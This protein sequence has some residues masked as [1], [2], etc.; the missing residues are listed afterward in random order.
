MPIHLKLLAMALFWALT[1]T[2]ARLLA[3]YEAP[4]VMVFGRF[5]IASSAL[6][7]FAYVQRHLTA[8]FDRRHFAGF[9]LLG[10]GTL[11]IA[12]LFLVNKTQVERG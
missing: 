11:V 3:P 7:V 10:G 6:L 8:K 2:I 4:H 9:A 5:L 1:P 12:G